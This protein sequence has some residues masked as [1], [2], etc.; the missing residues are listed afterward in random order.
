MLEDEINDCTGIEATELRSLASTIR[1][2][3]EGLH[4]ILEE[5]LAC[6]RF[7]KIKPE[8]QQVNDILERVFSLMEEE[9]RQKKIVFKKNFLHDLPPS[10]V[11]QDQIHRAFL[12]IVRNAIEAMGPGGGLLR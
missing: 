2:E 8:K 1:T 11:D 6:T 10:Y 3:I 12:N 9:L 4:N 5:Y 7:P